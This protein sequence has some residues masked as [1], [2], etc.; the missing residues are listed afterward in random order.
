MTAETKTRDD[1]LAAYEAGKA[2][3]RLQAERELHAERVVVEDELTFGEVLEQI[4]QASASDVLR[5]GAHSSAD[6]TRILLDAIDR[7]QYQYRTNYPE[8][9]AAM[10]LTAHGAVLVAHEDGKTTYRVPSPQIQKGSL[11]L[12]EQTLKVQKEYREGSRPGWSI[13]LG[14][15]FDRWT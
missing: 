2:F 13:D 12:H 9:W 3:G 5:L 4:N 14:A 10:V 8:G 1:V 6:L 11:D 7:G 15:Q